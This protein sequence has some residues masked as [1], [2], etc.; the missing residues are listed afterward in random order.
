[1][2]TVFHRFFVSFLSYQLFF[3]LLN[4]NA[5][6]NARVRFCGFILRGVAFVEQN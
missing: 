1:M 5:V 6:A 3:L 4:S 2:K